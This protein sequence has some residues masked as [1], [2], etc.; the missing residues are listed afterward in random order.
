MK[1]SPEDIVASATLISLE[2]SKKSTT[3]ELQTYRSFFLQLSNDL[4][5]IITERRNV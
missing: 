5:T 2:L 4:L 3:K 1:P